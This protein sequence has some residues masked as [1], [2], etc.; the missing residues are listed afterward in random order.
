MH[1]FPKGSTANNGK[2]VK[3]TKVL[4]KTISVCARRFSSTKQLKKL[5]NIQLNEKF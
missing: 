4:L 3:I 2:Y 5:E 1:L